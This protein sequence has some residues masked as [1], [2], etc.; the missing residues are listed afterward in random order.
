MTNG[1]IITLDGPAGSGKS[2]VARMLADHLQ[3]LYLDTGAMY[4]GVA[5]AAKQRGLGVEDG[6]ALGEL[7]A[8]IDM[9]FEVAQGPPRLILNGEDVSGAIRSPEMDLLSSS[10]SA[11]KE[12]RA[13]MTLLQ[14]NMA[15]WTDVVAE[16]RDMGTVVF[17]RATHKFFL[18]AT[19]GVRVD[20]RYAERLARGETVARIDVEREM[21][22][23]DLQD[24]T[25]SLAPLRPAEDA[26]VIDSSRL[27]P[28]QM[29]EQILI[30]V[31]EDHLIHLKGY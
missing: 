12:V 14:R 20:R 2:T 23:R 8:S 25:R 6:K 7:C 9:R 15:R 24:E 3:W 11:V 28:Y 10:V 18:T 4:R 13:A 30:R 21:K 29:M 27:T 22:Q 1:R 31:G 26:V 16:G 19:L 17:P 5:L